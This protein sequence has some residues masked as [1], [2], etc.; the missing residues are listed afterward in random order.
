MNE[1]KYSLQ[2]LFKSTEIKSRMN[3]YQNYQKILIEV[4]Q[5]DRTY[6][7]EQYTALH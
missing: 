2:R 1:L 6:Q 4:H 7:I 5:R 3:H